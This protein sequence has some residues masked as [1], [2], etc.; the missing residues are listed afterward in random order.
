MTQRT[1]QNRH[2]MDAAVS[3]C[4]CHLNN[5]APPSVA[6][7]KSVNDFDRHSTFTFSEA[8]PGH[9]VSSPLKENDMSNTAIE[10]GMQLLDMSICV[11][12]MQQQYLRL[13]EVGDVLSENMRLFNEPYRQQINAQGLVIVASHSRKRAQQL[14]ELIKE[15]YIHCTVIQ[16]ITKDISANDRM[17]LVDNNHKVLFSYNGA[18]ASDNVPVLLALVST[19]FDSH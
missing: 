4:Q 15:D 5:E 13:L 14:K 9:F 7:K 12:P 1:S 10:Q 16:V 17:V 8:Q 18:K 2:D 6:S 19:M 11:N 3:H